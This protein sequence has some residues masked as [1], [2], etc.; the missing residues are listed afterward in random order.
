MTPDRFDELTAR[1]EKLRIAVLGDFCLDRYLDIDPAREEISI[2]TGLPVHN[3]T[4][5]RS[6]P[7]AAGTI[8]NNL[9]ALGVGT[10]FPV[11]FCGEDGE[12]WELLRALRATPRAKIDSF[13]Q[14]PARRTFAYTKPLIHEPGTV[15]RELSRLDLKNWSPT[16][17]QVEEQIIAAA[18]RLA[19]SVDAFIVMDQVDLPDTGVVTQRV[20]EAIGGL[21][22]AHPELPVLADCRR[23]LHGWPPCIWKMNA[24]ELSS[25]EGIAAAERAALLDAAAKLAQANQR[26]VFVTLAENG[27]I[28]ADSTGRAEH[29]PAFP[30]RGEIDIVGAGD[31]V[32][33][34]LATALAAGASLRESMLMAMA[35]ASIV[36][37]QIGTTGTATVDAMR[38]LLYP[39]SRAD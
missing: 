12:G 39:G 24:R 5:V 36:I 4:G 13:L 20:Q 28:G 21:S 25:L 38:G 27:I 34:G 31:A 32:S 17:R 26:A 16:P 19:P 15:P 7:G 23:G 14:T 37:H 6:Q 1:Y 11:G 8:L 30:I 2:E 22:A 33:A 9:S 18:S 10:L 35:A 3:V 29:A